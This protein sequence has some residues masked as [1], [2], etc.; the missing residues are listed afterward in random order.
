MNIDELAKEISRGKELFSETVRVI[1]DFL[2][3]FESLEPAEINEF[4][5][6]RQA[7]LEALVGFHA[8]LK[9]ELQSGE[10]VLS[11]A[12]TKQLEEFRIFQEVFVQIIME[13]DAAIISQAT[14]TLERL[15]IEL[16]VVGRGKQALRGYNRRKSSYLNC[17]DK[18]A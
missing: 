5:R 9:Q 17:L 6:K 12:M 14:R 4:E 11:L 1:S 13:K 16:A 15:R 10:K 3:R 8:E 7:L 18:S 2:E